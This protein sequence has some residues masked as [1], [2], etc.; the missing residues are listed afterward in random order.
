MKKLFNFFLLAVVLLLS[1]CD[2]YPVSSVSLDRSS[3]TMD[4]GDTYQLECIIQPLSSAYANSTTWKSSDPSVAVVSSSGVVK[5][6]YSGT[7]I[8]TASAGNH[9]ATCEVVVNPL[10]YSFSFNRAGALYYGDAY[11]VG[12]HN[13][14]L[15]LLGNGVSM[16]QDG[17]LAGE[18]LFI[19]FDVQ[20]PLTDL[21]ITSGTYNISDVRS[22]YTFMPGQIYEESGTQYAIG[23]FVGQRTSEG[24]SVIFV[25]SGSFWITMT[26]NT[27]KLEA[28]LLGEKDEDIVINF[29]GVIPVIDKTET[30][31]PETIILDP[32]SAHMESL[33]DIYSVGLNV[34]RQTVT[35]ATDT[36]LQIEFY[37]PLSITGQ[38]PSGTYQFSGTTTYS[39]V[40]AS[41]D[42]GQ[43]H[44]TWFT[45]TQGSKKV[46]GGQVVVA[47]SD[48]IQ[49]FK[50]RLIDETDRII[51]VNYTH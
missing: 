17:S 16:D 3:F 49:S 39:L 24:L 44:G 26:G 13:F 20:L 51:D 1:A 34:F 22:E 42:N 18:G 9:K 15:R 40:T 11:D 43:L 8:I 4:A 7:C 12:S 2:E 46:V 14:V 23:T 10:E 45:D 32:V 30:N 50:Y 29:A 25:K 38:L 6:V 47:Q 31:P 27:Y 48:G 37:A 28:H 5:A 21:A 33:G 35:H 41:N 36:V 19:N